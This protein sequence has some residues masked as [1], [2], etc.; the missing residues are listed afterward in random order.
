MEIYMGNLILKRYTLV[1]DFRFF[2]MYLFLMSSKE[3]TL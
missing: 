3:L 1:H 2:Y